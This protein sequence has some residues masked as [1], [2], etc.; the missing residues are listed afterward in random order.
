MLPS[1]LQAI[2]S[3]QGGRQGLQLIQQWLMSGQRFDS[4]AAMVM[5]R[6]ATISS[7]KPNLTR[8]QWDAKQDRT[9]TMHG[10]HHNVCLDGSIALN[11][12]MS[13]FI[14]LAGLLLGAASASPPMGNWRFGLNPSMASSELAGRPAMA[15]GPGRPVTCTGHND[16]ENLP[17]FDGA[18]SPSPTKAG[19]PAVARTWV[20]A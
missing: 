10:Q 6:S 4:Y 18:H 13:V 19:T 5:S 12:A 8:S 16:C 9:H 15:D 3:R 1:V 2:R 11:S 14:F 7:E 17:V 20:T